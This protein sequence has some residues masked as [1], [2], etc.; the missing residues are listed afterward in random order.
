M[1]SLGASSFAADRE[2]LPA[3]AVPTHYFISLTPDLKNR[4]FAGTATL[5]FRLRHP[6]QRVVVNAIDLQVVSAELSDGTPATVTADAAHER[7]S[8]SFARSLSSGPHAITVRYTGKIMDSAIGMFI[9]DYPATAGPRRALTTQLE[10]GDAR[11][12]APLWDEPALK[13]VFE[14]EIN[15]AADWQAYSNMP[16]AASRL[17]SNGLKATRFAATP[18]MSSYLLHFT[19]G[20]LDRISRRGAGSASSVDIGVIATAQQAELGRYAL[21]SAALLLDYY[22]DY[23]GVPYPLPKLDLIALAGS[24]GF[25]AMENW[26]AI[27][28]FERFL[29][30]DP[31][32]SSEADRQLVYTDLAHEISHQWFGNLVTMQWW[33]DL[34]LNEAFASWM[35]NK[36]TAAA[37]PEWNPWLGASQSREAALALDARASTHPIVQAV[38]NSTAANSAFDSITYNK[39]QEVIRMLESY[40]GADDFRAGI[41][42][43]LRQHVFGNATSADLWAALATASG[44]PVRSIAHDFTEQAGVPLIEVLATHC[45]PT[46]GMTTLQLRQR[47]FGVD[48]QSQQPRTWRVPVT[49]ANPG[50]AS[51]TA[52]VSGDRPQALTVKGCGATKLNFGQSGYY[53]VR[54]DTASAR[55]LAAALPA[56]S[57][58]DQ[59][60]LLDDS[61]ALGLAGY[62]P[63]A[64][65]LRMVQQ[66]PL[67]ADPLVLNRVAESL[68]QL[69]RYYVDLPGQPGLRRFALT[70]LRP[71]LNNVGW[72]RRSDE[73]DNVAVLRSTLIETLAELQDE[74]VQRHVRA[75]FE[76]SATDANAIPAG[77]YD[78][79][80]AAAGIGA[81]ATTYAA[82]RSRAAAAT[83]SIKQEQ[84]LMAAARVADQAL[85]AKSLND[86]LSADTPKQLAIWLVLATSA[87]H[88]DQ[89]WT[90]LSHHYRQLSAGIDSLMAVRAAPDL[91]QNIDFPDAAARLRSFAARELPPEAQAR[92]EAACAAIRY[93]AT[94][95]SQ[96]LPDMDRW[97]A[98]Q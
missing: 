74:D 84:L 91:A 11:R 98:T 9:S 4:R 22:N 30:L 64:D 55:A 60:G 32:V 78:A 56:L 72:D 48:A 47:R 86:T 36:A 26:G 17:L 81:D 6:A 28:F 2:V 10:P 3:N 61:L 85:A 33:N 24:G 97:L 82:L 89:A 57:P 27:L 43:Y 66:L 62:T 53:R 75:L 77:I 35:E 29:L 1:L 70:T 50:S 16:V 40:V 42:A 45:E 96:R 41:R 21:D 88:A 69:H 49:A 44:K 37:H 25:A 23:F 14:I 76:S 51:N 20:E 67:T 52:L 46:S 19:V 65:Y 38:R 8:F 68:R 80:I 31:A 39:G 63:L 18:P 34:W 93:R 87:Q 15:A 5:D 12:I 13:A 7:M 94:I 83:N 54:Y 58:N 73:A 79:V 90:F 92:V 59:Q 71:I 95:R